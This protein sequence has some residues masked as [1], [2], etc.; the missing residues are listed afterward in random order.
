ML[1]IKTT[2]TTN[3]VSSGFTGIALMIFNRFVATIF[4]VN[5]TLP[6]LSTGIF[7]VAFSIMVLSVAFQKRISTGGVRLI[8]ALDAIWVVGSLLLIV[9]GSHL[10]SM[11]GLFLIAAVA[12]WVALMIVLQVKGLQKLL[13][14]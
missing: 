14:V 3:A 5:T 12:G 1:P 4:E 13:S 6:F 2:L 8:I 9:A 11:I 7:L 10:I